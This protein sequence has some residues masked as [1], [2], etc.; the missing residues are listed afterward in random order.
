MSGGVLWRKSSRSEQET[1]STMLSGTTE[2]LYKIIGRQFICPHQTEHKKKQPRRTRIL[3]IVLFSFGAKTWWAPFSRY[4]CS[5]AD[6]TVTVPCSRVQVDFKRL[7]AAHVDLTTND[8]THFPASTRRPAVFCNHPELRCSAAPTV[9]L[10]VW[11]SARLRLQ[12][13]PSH[14]T[15]SSISSCAGLIWCCCCLWSNRLVNLNVF[16]EKKRNAWN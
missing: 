6:E 4:C 10:T 12:I 7:L 1:S 11:R 16:L 5:A 2:Q 9:S 3:E 8:V 13:F 14:F 15:Q